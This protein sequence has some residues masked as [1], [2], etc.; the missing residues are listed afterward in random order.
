MDK[1]A[2]DLNKEGINLEIDNESEKNIRVK[3][4]E[5]EI[6]HSYWDFCWDIKIF[7]WKSKKV[8]RDG[9]KK[10]GDYCSS[11]LWWFSA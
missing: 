9:S 5:F 1:S 3:C 7:V 11:L 8:H 10:S 6:S 2:E 4:S